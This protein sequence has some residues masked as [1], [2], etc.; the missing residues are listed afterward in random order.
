VKGNPAFAAFLNAEVRR[1]KRTMSREAQELLI[2]AVGKDVRCLAAACSQL[3]ADVEGKNIDA[4]AVRMY[5]GGTAA[6]EGYRVSD[7]VMAKQGSAALR[8][9]R[10][11]EGVEGVRAGPAIV[12]ALASGVRQQALVSAVPPGGGDQALARE[13]NIQPWKLKPVRERARHWP[14]RDLA[15]A[16][17]RLA[18]LDAAVKGGLRDGDYLES[19]Q[20]GL[21]L[22]NAVTELASRKAPTRRP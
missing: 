8:L 13:I 5:F 14:S 19:S 22:E 17:L 21:A 7:A 12:A 3:A 2:A 18:D 16:V 15:R 11:S 20:K 1:H 10:L 9:L 6:I 4:E